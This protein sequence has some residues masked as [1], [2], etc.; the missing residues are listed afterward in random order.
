MM[1]KI[2]MTLSLLTALTFA[3]AANAAAPPSF[4][5]TWELD[6]SK[7]QNLSRGMQDAESVSLIITQSDK[8]I[9]TETKITPGAAAAGAPAGGGPGGGGGGGRG[10]F[11]GAMGPVSY[12]ADG[13]EATTENERGKTTTKATWAGNNLELSAKR[14]FNTPNGEVTATTTDK[15]SLSADGKVLTIT[16]HS[17]S[18]RGPQDSTLVYNKKG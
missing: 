1:R 16:R 6:K 14:T 4:A 7:S 5:G 3:F 12:N 2:V 11:G 13:S 17:E 18:P 15:L 9:T 10:G 8:T